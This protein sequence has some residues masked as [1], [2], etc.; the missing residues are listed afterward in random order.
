MIDFKIKAQ[1]YLD[2][3]DRA[4]GVANITI[5]QTNVPYKQ[6]RCPLNILIHLSTQNPAFKEK[7]EL[8]NKYYRT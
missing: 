4:S 6:H 3:A 7:F 1:I 2:E 8:K 5:Q